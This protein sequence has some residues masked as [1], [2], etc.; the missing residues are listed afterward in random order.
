MSRTYCRITLL[1]GWAS[2]ACLVAVPQARGNLLAHWDFDQGAGQTAVD[3]TGNGN[4]GILGDNG[5]DLTRDPAWVGGLFGG[6]L[7]FDAGGAGNQVRVPFPHTVQP[8]GD[9]TMSAWVNFESFPSTWQSVIQYPF[10]NA[11]H[12]SPFFEYAIYVNQNGA[13]H[14][15]IDGN[16]TGLHGTAIGLAQWHHLAIAYDSTT[17]NVDHFVDGALAGSATVGAGGITYDANNDVI[18]GMNASTSERVDGLVDDTGMFGDALNL[19]EVNAIISLGLEPTLQYE[20]SEVDQLLEA[21]RNSTPEVTIGNLDWSLITDGSIGGAPGQ[22]SS[23]IVN[24]LPSLAINL[25]GGNGLAIVP[26]PE[27]SSL[28][29][30]SLALVPAARRLRRRR[31]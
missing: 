16:S 21:F 30:C 14:S 20:L 18:F 9:L 5:V 31:A 27:P 28:L 19:A 17:G 4:D 24:G 11:T 1:A 22:L 3:I 23:T 29:L 25:G 8:G 10:N 6:A 7:D 12:S 15:R 26:V 2:L 13:I